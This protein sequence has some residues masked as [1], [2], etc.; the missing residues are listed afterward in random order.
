MQL[1][2]KF[3]RKS[4]QRTN[5]FQARTKFESRWPA[6]DVSSEWHGLAASG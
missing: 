5:V 3:S 6:L 2:P 1:L 4:F